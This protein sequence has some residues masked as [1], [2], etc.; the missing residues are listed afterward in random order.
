MGGQSEGA[1][2]ISQDQN[3]AGAIDVNQMEGA[4]NGDQ[5]LPGVV[6]TGAELQGQGADGN[7]MFGGEQPQIQTGFNKKVRKCTLCYCT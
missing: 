4:Q 3:L 1:A 2:G 6:G 5:Q 7:Q